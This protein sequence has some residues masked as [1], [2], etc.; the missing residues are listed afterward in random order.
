MTTLAMLF[1][2]KHHQS[3]IFIN[4]QMR[5]KSLPKFS[6][7]FVTLEETFKEAALLSDKKVSQASY[8]PVKM[9][10]KFEI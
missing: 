3:I 8:I 2:Y 10:K 5:E 6:F 7:H 4:K 9:I 1:K